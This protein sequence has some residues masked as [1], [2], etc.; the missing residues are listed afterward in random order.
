MDLKAQLS[1]YFGFTVFKTGQR[2]VIEK[3]MQGRSALAV[4]HTGAGKSLCYQLPAVLLPKMTLVV[5]PLLSLMKDQVD[6]LRDKAISAA[7][8]DSSLSPD[9]YRQVLDQAKKGDLRVLMVAVERFKNERF[10]SQLNKMDVSLMVVDEAHCISEWGHNFRPDYLKLPKYRQ[11]F[12]IPQVLLL[13]AT[14]TPRVRRDMCAKFGIDQDDAVVTGFYR[15]NL[16]LQVSPTPEADKQKA[17]ISRLRQNPQA[18][19]IVYVTLQKTAEQV[20]EVLQEIGLQTRAYHAGLDSEKRETVQ[21]EFMAGRLPCV[22]AT[23]AFGMGIDKS[24]IR[25]IIHFDL[26]KSLEN[27]SQEIGRAGRDGQEALCEV[28][29]NKDSLPL[30][31]N[32]V[33]GDMPEKSSIKAL[34]ETIAASE[35]SEWEVRLASLST[36]LNMRILPLKTLLVYLELN[37]ILEPRAAYYAEYE[38]QTLVETDRILQVFHG[39]RRDFVGIIFKHSRRKRTWTSVDIPAIAAESGSARQRVVTALEFFEEQGWIKLKTRGTVDFFRILNKGFDLSAVTENIYNLYQRKQEFEISRIHLMLRFFQS[40]P[41]L[42]YNLA[43]YFGES[44]PGKTC[45]HCSVCCTGQAAVLEK[46]YE[47][48]PL[49]DLDRGDLFQVCTQILGDQLTLDNAAKFLCGV[50]APV[51][52]RLKASKSPQFGALSGYPFREVKEWLANRFQQQI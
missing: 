52:T 29:A 16:N 41:C 47:T 43:R 50:H 19:T 1:K 23:I 21:N 34:L 32:F 5:S 4:F 37:R 40:S 35:N 51:F 31:E 39:E 9:E 48:P 22:V 3:I 6:F 15:A 14:A 46:T 11:E 25:Q 18:A 30:L 17:L 42:S 36:E 33:Y 10:R 27:Y 24:D 45:G 26:P 7:R 12:D 2:E 8:L 38:F 44:V 13:T 28:L 20:A 49:S